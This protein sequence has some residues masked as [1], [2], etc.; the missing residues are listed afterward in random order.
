[1]SYPDEEERYKEKQFMLAYV[2][3]MISYLD[4]LK[5]KEVFNVLS[6]KIK[7]KK[8]WVIKEYFE[9]INNSLYSNS[10]DIK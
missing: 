7:S 10:I 3:P 5:L 8:K 4:S 1:D 6:H 2:A 9:R